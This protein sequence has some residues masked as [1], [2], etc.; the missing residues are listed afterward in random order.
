MIRGLPSLVLYHNGEPVAI[1]SGAIT[2]MELEDWLEE[3]LSVVVSND[4]GRK[5]VEELEGEIAVKLKRE[6]NSS[7]SV[8]GESE[9]IPKR[10]FVSFASQYGRDDYAL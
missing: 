5:R 8:G 10:G 1:H 4:D 2:E 7:D 9:S 3:H 6:T